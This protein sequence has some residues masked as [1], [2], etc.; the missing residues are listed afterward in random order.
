MLGQ[1]HAD[2]VPQERRNKKR[3]SRH[4][5]HLPYRLE[6]SQRLLAGSARDGQRPPQGYIGLQS[7]RRPTSCCVRKAT[8]PA[9]VESC[10]HALRVWIDDRQCGGRSHWR[11]S[12]RRDGHH[13]AARK[14]RFTHLYLGASA[15]INWARVVA[16][17]SVDLISACRMLK[18]K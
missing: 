8:H 2:A 3:L 4:E 9:Q 7:I 18:Q 13:H 12:L 17:E 15:K 6:S 10:D 16:S 5:P 1:A 14:R 11:P